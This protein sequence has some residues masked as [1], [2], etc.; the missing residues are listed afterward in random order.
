MTPTRRHK[1]A[2]GRGS[3]HYAD[4]PDVVI[5]LFFC[6]LQQ[7]RN[8][9]EY[10]NNKNPNISSLIELEDTWY[11]NMLVMK[12]VKGMVVDLEPDSKE[13]KSITAA[14]TE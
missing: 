3:V 4:D 10:G 13:M 14:L 11:G 8:E 6:P 7:I 2:L 12:T 1:A 9:A 5:K